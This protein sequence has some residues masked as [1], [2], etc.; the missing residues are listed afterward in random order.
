MKILWVVSTIFPQLADNLKRPVP[1]VGG[2]MYGLAKSL[3]ETGQLKLTIVTTDSHLEIEREIEDIRFVLLKSN[4]PKQKYDSSLEDKWRKTIDSHKPDLIHI[5]GTEY[6]LG[7]SLLKACPNLKFVISIQ[8]IISIISRYYKG[9]MG[10]REIINS[11]TFRDLVRGDTIFQAQRKM[12]KRGFQE[13]KYFLMVNNIIGRTSWDKYH[14]VNYNPKR[15]YY[16]CNESLRPNFYKSPK[17]DIDKKNTHSIF[18][19]Q[20]AYP[21]KGLHQVLK[22]VA[23][24][25]NEY[26]DLTIRIGGDD[27]INKPVLRLNGY[28]KYICQ[29]IKKYKLQK[30][31]EFLGAL[32][33]NEMIQ[34][35][36]Q[37]HVF[38]CPSSIENSPNSLGEAQLL[39]VPCIA[40][41]VGGVPDMVTHQKDGLIYRFEEVEILAHH[42]RTIFNG[43]SLAQK[44]SRNGIVTAS[45]RH[46]SITNLN[47]TISIYKKIIG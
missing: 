46:N 7:L 15:N 27:I 25:S 17:W 37:S 14:T 26:E 47:A 43:D 19:S 9:G 8:G 10:S 31:V 2:W 30:N 18:L 40:A 5:H 11:F 16:F 4:L 23:L 24:I 44:L 42:I 28:G 39:G 20:A 33:E 3:S 1:F 29:L 41:Y 21:L 12:Q 32:D 35:Y 45:D 6:S 34:E 22:A 13:N 36:L 38:V